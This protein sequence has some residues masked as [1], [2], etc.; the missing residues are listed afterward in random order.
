MEDIG[1]LSVPTLETYKVI[2]PKL[3]YLDEIVAV[4]EK[5]A[6]TVSET[7][8][9]GRFPLVLGRITALRSARSQGWPNTTANWA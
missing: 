5:L 9:K 1:N 4:N 3:K 8:E 6:E 7:V 2:D